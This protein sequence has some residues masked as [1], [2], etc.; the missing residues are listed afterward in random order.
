[1]RKIFKI[2]TLFLI[3]T[4][5]IGCDDKIQSLEDLNIEPYSEYY[6]ISNGI[7]L[8]NISDN[9]IKDSV[10]FYNENNNLPYSISIRFKDKNRNFDDFIKKNMNRIQVF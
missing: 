9:T 6:S 3:T 8:T 2:T 1:M 5:F 7:W 10:K 4:I